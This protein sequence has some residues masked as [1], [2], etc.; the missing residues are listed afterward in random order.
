MCGQAEDCDW[1]SARYHLGISET[2]PLIEKKYKGIG[3]PEK[4]A[5]WL[6]SDQTDLKELRYYF[7]IGR[8]LGG[9]SF[10]KQA[11]IT[12][13]RSLFPQKPGR[14]KTHG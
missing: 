10:I 6:K 12:T 2:D 14:P 7:R 13:G 9:E 3:K 8:P 1:S 5:K 11:E 4:W